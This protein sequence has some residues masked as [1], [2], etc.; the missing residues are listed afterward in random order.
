M[1]VH[2]SDWIEQAEKRGQPL[3]KVYWDHGR[4]RSTSAFLFANSGDFAPG[5]EIRLF[6]LHSDII[7]ARVW[8]N[9]H[10]IPPAFPITLGTWDVG[11]YTTDGAVLDAG[12]WY[13]A[14]T[15]NAAR[16]FEDLI[17]TPSASFNAQYSHDPLW[18]VLDPD[19][20]RDPNRVWEIRMASSGGM[21]GSQN[22]ALCVGAYYLA[23]D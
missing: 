7:M 16:L 15:L 23:G 2:Q 6:Q 1:T 3:N 18:K 14:L 11:L 17:F 12:F 9:F 5:D 13:N 10:A 22:F 21:S 19:G 8:L 4:M 20:T